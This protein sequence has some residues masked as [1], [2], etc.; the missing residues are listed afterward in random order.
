MK[1][2]PSYGMQYTDLR[3]AAVK[4][5]LFRTFRRGFPPTDSGHLFK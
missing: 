1:I 5:S 3:A 4:V 2:M